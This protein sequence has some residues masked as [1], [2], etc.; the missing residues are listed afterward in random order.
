MSLLSSACTLAGL[1]AL[2]S[3]HVPA[4][5]V[6]L[7]FASPGVDEAALIMHLIPA[8]RAAAA[9]AESAACGR[10]G[11]ALVVFHVGITRVEGDAL[12]GAAV[13]RITDLYRHLAR[14]A[15]GLAHGQE[16][17]V[18]ISTGLF[19]DLRVDCGFDQ[20]WRPLPGADAWF[21]GYQA[22][23]ATPRLTP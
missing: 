2:Y 22:D 5:A 6:D 16:L 15:A 12:A 7:G 18:G 11:P 17:L 23:T 19:E 13:R 4:D 9:P 8:L 1:A 10:A 14:T 3:E 21:R 20:H